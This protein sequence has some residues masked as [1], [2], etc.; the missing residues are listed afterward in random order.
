[1]VDTP[2]LRLQTPTLQDLKMMVA[3]A[4]DAQAQRWLGWL[5]EHTIREPYRE[6]LLTRKPGRGL[7]FRSRNEGSLYLVAVDKARERLAG[8]IGY[9]G[10]RGEVGGWLTPSYR[11]RGFGTELFTGA[12]FFVHHHLGE[13]SVRA[14]TETTNSAAASA[15]RS[16]GFHPTTGPGTYV[17]PDGRAIPSQWFRHD[18]DRPG[19]CRVR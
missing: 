9:N 15:L 1:V 7:S 16:A 10:D 6:R 5:P 19:L 12:A 18:T 8:A 3:A 11:S 13:R 2:R 17:L 4:S 14:G